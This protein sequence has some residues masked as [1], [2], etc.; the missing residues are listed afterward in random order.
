M[1]RGGWVYIM[2]DRYRGTL[3]VGVTAN[4]PARIH[5]HRE[6]DGSDFCHRYGLHRL[7]WA[8]RSDTIDACIAHEKRLKKWRR[9]WK[10]ELIEKANPDWSDLFDVVV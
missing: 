8:D 1:K 9:E 6:G 3:Y 10:I 7:V 4:L 2:A 5:Q